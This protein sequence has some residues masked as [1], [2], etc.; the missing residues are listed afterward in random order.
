MAASATP[1]SRL[2]REARRE[3]L[4]DAAAELTVERGSGAVTMERLAEW[5]GVSKALPYSHF[6][7]SD[8]VLI[9]LYQRVVGKLGLRIIEALEQADADDDRVSLIV[10]TYFDTVA[11]LGPILGAVTAPGSQTLELADGDRRVGP[12]FVSQL[13]SEHF[14]LSK[15]DARAV[16]PVLL[17]SLTGTVTAWV[18]GDASR[19]RAERMSVDIMRVL[20]A[21]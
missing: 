16:A 2:S 18:E 1:R 10:T 11:D 20:L 19:T 7:N 4:L 6:E 3:Q 5:A 9:A 21:Q 17:A 12:N 14:G 8:D 15:T 13:L